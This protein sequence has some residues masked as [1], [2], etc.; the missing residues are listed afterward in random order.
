MFKI[1]VKNGT[2]VQ[3]KDLLGV[4]QDPFGEFKKKIY[5]PFDCYIF[6][7]NKTPIVNKGDAL[8]HVSFEE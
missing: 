1:L 6:C 4:I 3:K 8:F 7:I 5:A 2:Q